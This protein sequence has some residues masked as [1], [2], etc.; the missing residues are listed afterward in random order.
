MRKTSIA[1][2]LLAS[3]VL[4]WSLEAA[5]SQLTPEETSALDTILMAYP[6]LAS[7]SNSLLEYYKDDYGGSWTSSTSLACTPGMTNPWNFYGIH[8]DASGHVDAI[9]MYVSLLM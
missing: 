4:L 6:A 5:T 2:L 7:L 9:V 3:F 8:C 1:R